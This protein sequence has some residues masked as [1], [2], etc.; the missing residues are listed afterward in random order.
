[1]GVGEL[2][3]RNIMDEQV[4]LYYDTPIFGELITITK[5]GI[6]NTCQILID[7][8]HDQLIHGEYLYY[9]YYTNL[10][11]ANS[12]CNPDYSKEDIK[13]FAAVYY[14]GVQIVRNGKIH[15]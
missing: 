4:R 5:T 11:L 2:L 7:P 12:G 3:G 9:T 15:Y 8:K 6:V 1:M 10:Y 13:L 14:N